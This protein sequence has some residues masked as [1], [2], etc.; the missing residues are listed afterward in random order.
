MHEQATNGAHGAPF[1]RPWFAGLGDNRR[2]RNITRLAW[3][4]L[5]LVSACGVAPPPAAHDPAVSSSGM[6]FRG[7]RACVDCQRIQ[8]WLRLEHDGSNQRYRLVE[9]YRGDGGD[10]RFEDA[11]EWT[12]KGEL[13]RLR[14]RDGGGERVYAR[15]PDGRLQARGARG[16]SLPAAMDDVM[17]PV[18]FD[19]TR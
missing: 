11:G 17:I 4:C 14:S 19:N 15:L 6:E 3:P 16:Q 18:T 9:D 1:V 2:M 7:E 12:A 10:R 13:L 5:L 8:A